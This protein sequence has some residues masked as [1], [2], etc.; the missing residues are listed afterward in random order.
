MFKVIVNPKITIYCPL[1]SLQ[2]CM[3]SHGNIFWI[4]LVT[5]QFWLLT[6]SVK[7]NKKNLNFFTITKHFFDFQTWHSFLCG[8]QKREE[9]KRKW[10]SL[11][12][13]ILCPH[14]WVWMCVYHSKRHKKTPGAGGT[15]LGF[16][17]WNICLHLHIYTDT[18]INAINHQLLARQQYQLHSPCKKKKTWFTNHTF[19]HICPQN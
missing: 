1:M 14:I 12:K 13:D 9:E 19:I 8:T 4:I 10:G 2:I 3:H 5:K 16:H 11:W 17:S 6:S 15:V 18:H 7:K